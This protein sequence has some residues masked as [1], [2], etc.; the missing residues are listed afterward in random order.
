MTSITFGPPGSEWHYTPTTK[1]FDISGPSA[2]KLTIAT[3][4]GP[5]DTSVTIAPE[6]SALV[7]VDMQNFFLDASCMAHPNGLKAVEPTIAIIKKCR[8][9]G[10][11]V[12]PPH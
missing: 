3:T 9:A 8:E 1:T 10:I 11:Q 6:S 5:T 7:V 4:E 12:P 2:T